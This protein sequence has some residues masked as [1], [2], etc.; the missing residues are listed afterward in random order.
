MGNYWSISYSDKMDDETQMQTEL[1]Y[2]SIMRGD[3]LTIE[4]S[5][6]HHQSFNYYLD[7]ITGIHYLALS[8]LMVDLNHFSTLT[9][10]FI[11]NDGINWNAKTKNFTLS[12]HIEESDLDADR[13]KR[14][15]YEIEI[16]RTR[17]HVG[18]KV[19]WNFKYSLKHLSL[20]SLITRLQIISLM[21]KSNNKI[22]YNLNY[23]IKATEKMFF[24][25]IQ[26]EERNH[27]SRYLCVECQY[28]SVETMLS[29]R[30]A[31]LCNPCAKKIKECPQCLEVIKKD[32]IKFFQFIHS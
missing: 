2:H 31:L 15:P 30:H 17:I 9:S 13:M 18:G 29:C 22:S 10:L 11:E 12:L 20:S 16:K 3:Y 5:M 14:K 1:N 21:I 7:D 8:A 32:K 4:N 27:T 28:L 26:P 24:Y 25:R 19:I 6:Y 23:L